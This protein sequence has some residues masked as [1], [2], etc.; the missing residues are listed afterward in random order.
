MSKPLKKANIY[1]PI[2]SLFFGMI[3]TKFTISATEGI[4]KISFKNKNKIFFGIIRL[5]VAIISPTK[6]TILATLIFK[7]AILLMNVI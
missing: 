7:L 6:M 5:L 3:F 2:I 4:K 1:L